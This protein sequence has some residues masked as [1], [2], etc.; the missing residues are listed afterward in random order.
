MTRL[1]ILCL[2]Q[3]DEALCN[4]DRIC[5]NVCP[6]AAIRVIEKKARVDGDRCVACLKCVDACPENAV[7][8]E[9]EMLRECD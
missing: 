4:G 9:L 2:A 7:T 3:V 1:E 8:L 5:E 6:T